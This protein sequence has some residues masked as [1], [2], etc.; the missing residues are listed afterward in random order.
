[1]LSLWVFQAVWGA[2]CEHSR[3]FHR[4]AAQPFHAFRASLFAVRRAP[5]ISPGVI[6][7]ERGRF[8]GCVMSSP[9][10][11]ILRAAK[12]GAFESCVNSSK[13]QMP[14][15]LD[16]A[17]PG[18]FE[19]PTLCLEERQSTNLLRFSKTV[20][21]FFDCLSPFCRYRGAVFAHA[22]EPGPRTGKA[23]FLNLESQ[24]DLLGFR[25]TLLRVA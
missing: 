4:R 16:L 18:R 1:M 14:N 22:V 15:L 19:L 13:P 12:G 2:R 20:F 25:E 11:P 24:S 5:M 8:S 3:S 23:A 7:P 9:G 17:R 21:N 6:S 10:W